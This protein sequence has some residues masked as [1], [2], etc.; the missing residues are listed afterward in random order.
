[1]EKPELRKIMKYRYLVMSVGLLFAGNCM[2]ENYEFTHRQIVASPIN[3][4]A[5][6]LFLF[7]RQGQLIHYSDSYLQNI[8][9]IFRKKELLPNS[10]QLKNDL[11]NLLNK[12]IDFSAHDYTLFYTSIDE[13][14]GPCE[15]CRQQEEKIA[16]LDAK[17][18]KDKLSIHRITI[19][20]E[21]YTLKD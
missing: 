4:T 9:S 19:I 15:P 6:Q 12:N 1:L 21:V 17:F 7:N 11:F 18:P 8:L 13:A 20:N 10:E 3:N 14:I 5:P 2:A 16:L